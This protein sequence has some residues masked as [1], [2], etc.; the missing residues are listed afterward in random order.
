MLASCDPIVAAVC[1]D[2]ET[3]SCCV[4]TWYALCVAAYNGRT[5]NAC[6]K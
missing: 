3:A 2:E 6:K 1:A 5:D 4:S